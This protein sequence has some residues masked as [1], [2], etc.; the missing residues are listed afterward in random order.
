ML[1]SGES[2]VIF[3]GKGGTGKSTCAAATS[4]HLAEESG[5]RVLLLSI[6]PAGSLGDIFHLTIEGSPV[7]VPG[8]E[9]LQIIQL[10]ANSAFRE[11]KDLY[12]TYL[13]Q[14]LGWGTYLDDSD[15]SQLLDLRLP[16]IDEVSAVIKLN[17]FLQGEKYD[18][19][20]LDT[21]PTGH[22]YP[23]LDLPG[24]MENWIDF[25]D[26]LAEKHRFIK[27]SLVGDYSEEEAERFLDDQ[28]E[29]I[30]TVVRLLSAGD[31]TRFFPVLNP[32][33]L[34][35]HETA[36]LF[37]NTDL[38]R[39][40][41]SVIFNKVQN[42]E[43]CDVCEART[44]KSKTIINEFRKDFPGLGLVTVRRYSD[45]IYDI[46]GLRSVAGELFS[47]NSESDPVSD[48]P[49][50]GGKREYYSLSAVNGE[51]RIKLSSNYIFFG[52]KGGTGKSTLSAAAALSLAGDEE[53]NVLMLSIDPAGS[54]GDIF[55]KRVSSEPIKLWSSERGSV[56]G[57]QTD[58][59][60]EIESLK[61]KYRLAITEGFKNYAKS[62]EVKSEF[63]EQILSK[64]F[65]LIPPGISEIAALI[66]LLDLAKEESYDNVIID[67]PPTGHLTRFLELPDLAS[68][69]L[70]ALLD[71]LIKYR[72]VLDAPRITKEILSLSR[73]VRNLKR[74]LF[75]ESGGEAE[76][77]IVSIPEFLAIR[78]TERLATKAEN[79]GFGKVHLVINKVIRGELCPVCQKERQEQERQINAILKSPA[80]DQVSVT[81]Y[82]TAGP[83]NPTE[84]QKFSRYF[85]E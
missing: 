30:E 63:D 66:N 42:S 35:Y 83:L 58:P 53:R 84:L 64:L 78:E 44:Q 1:Y 4:L 13:S 60:T 14:L 85:L 5:L 55:S 52:G 80:Y 48:C 74:R 56:Y 71:I 12:G 11:Y 8:V 61:E 37:E 3:G 69:W 50:N 24:Q 15:I 67:T 45:P 28:R 16:G 47:Q 34:S 31:L 39:I 38:S 32:D 81:P 65:T 23:L 49:T 46:D 51:K 70:R 68:N 41:E 57:I 72:S 82:L 21:P 22:L 7:K 29:D 73:K 20:V 36:R 17:E 75:G 79:I 2:L 26:L 43:K 10:D 76:L 62:A 6:D 18:V 9:G 25:L 40:T 19:V 54:L 59:Q 27:S 33:N 77:I